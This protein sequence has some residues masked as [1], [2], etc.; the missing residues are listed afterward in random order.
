MTNT[1]TM[2]AF[3]D[4]GS[5]KTTNFCFAA[6]YM[7]E[8]T[9]KPVRWVTAEPV[10]PYQ[11]ALV[12]A[13]IVHLCRLSA[14]AE[15]PLVVLRKLSVG[16]WPVK[17]ATGQWKMSPLDK[18]YG[19]HLKLVG[20]T[21]SAYFVETLDSIGEVFM[22]DIRSKARK[23]SEELVGMF[24]EE[25]E[26]FAANPRSHYGFVQREVVARLVS[27]SGLPVERVFFSAHER[28][29]EEDDEAKSP[30][31]GPAIVGKAATD[32][33]GKDVGTLLHCD[34]VTTPLVRKIEGKDVQTLEA[35]ARWYFVNHPD[36]RIQNVVYKCKPRFPPSQIKTLMDR[37]PGGY[38][39]PGL[40]YGV[41]GL[42]EYLRFED[43]VLATQTSGEKEWKVQVD[44][45]RVAPPSS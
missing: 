20:E 18:D 44:A 24:V 3:G 41:S 40:E 42:D 4:S 1:N 39:E 11:Q 37:W 17:D 26:K 7:Y 28:R 6:K 38:F 10:I 29:A 33:I 13:G 35:K 34:I 2:L 12:D 14:A 31:R 9:G 36:S 19:K 43:Q 22:E 30:I 23:I 25:D 21:Y 5:Y 15:N 8:K 16:F 45:K 32:K 27:F